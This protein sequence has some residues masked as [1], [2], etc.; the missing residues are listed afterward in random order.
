MDLSA[1]MEMLLSGQSLDEKVSGDVISSVMQGHYTPVQI[2]AFLTALRCKGETVSE[3]A[4]AARAMRRHAI[5]IMTRR[6]GIMDT[7]GTGGDRSGSFNISTTAAFVVAGAGVPVAKHGNRSATSQCGSIDLLEQL[8][9]NVILSAERMGECLDEVGLSV[10]FARVVHP[11][12]KYAAPV[13]SEL[14]FRTIF[15]FLGPLTNPA[16]PEF[17]LVGISDGSRLETYAQCL[18]KLGLRR[19]WVV[20]ASDGLDEITLT[21]PTRYI[22]VT[23]DSLT[24]GEIS[25]N[26]VGLSVCS[27]ADLKGGTLADNAAITRSI[28]EGNEKG[29]KRDIT[30]LNAGTALHIA[31]KS[32]SIREG[33]ELARQS[34]ALGNAAAILEKLITFTNRSIN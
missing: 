29:P 4:G 32:P 26:D 5:P 28:L 10:L 19:A 12:M 3:I 27:P 21:G 14:K 24:L 9:V 13:R 2:A 34:L 16:S 7:C 11:A 15:N 18:Q 17:Q 8:G 6:Q 1:I 20:S 30:L 25:P 31:G 23:Q 33:I 22:D